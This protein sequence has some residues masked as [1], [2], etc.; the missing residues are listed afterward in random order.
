MAI[1]NVGKKKW[2]VRI[3]YRP[4]DE[5]D[6][7]RN[8]R[9]RF[10]SRDEAKEF[11]N[12]YSNGI[13]YKTNN[14]L[15][16]LEV[17]NMYL[18]MN[19]ATANKETIADKRYMADKFLAPL[20]KKK[21]S[22][23]VAKDYLQIWISISESDYSVNRKNKVVTLIKSISR[24]AHDY[25]DFKDNSKPLQKFKETSDDVVE[26]KTWTVDEFYEF[27]S[28]VENEYYEAYFI[29]AFRTGARRGEIR[30]LLK[31]DI[32]DD[33]VT[34][35]KS[36][37][38]GV[39]SI[40]VLKTKGSRRAIRLDQQ[41]I[42]AIDNIIDY[43]GE[44]LF[45]GLEPLS[46]SGIQREMNKAIAKTN[47]KRSENSIEPLHTIKLHDLRHSHASILISEGANIVAVSKRLG[48]SDI[49]TTLRTYTH[50]L[51]KSEDE[52]MDILNEL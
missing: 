44:Y 37:R 19:S 13:D 32:V 16:Y 17:M 49:D 8:I 3:S 28:N 33:S 9:R 18:D 42:N 25:H 7:V 2:E 30:A 24:F 48:H 50:L 47:A 46:N 14:E 15:T 5:P 4:K 35:T 40:S 12:S 41:T 1:K 23:V 26:M 20:Y 21:Y 38:R 27:V 52:L 31:S 45:G 34:I 29:F 51:K 11:E 39:D 36:M 10:N 43:P 22:R 6:K